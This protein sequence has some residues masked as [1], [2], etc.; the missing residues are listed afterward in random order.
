MTLANIVV[1]ILGIA[2]I[3]AVWAVVYISKRNNE[4]CD[5]RKKI[6]HLCHERNV[7]RIIQLVPNPANSWVLFY[8]N[9]PSYDSML[10]SFKPLKLESY[11]TEEEINELTGDSITFEELTEKF[12]NK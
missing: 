11:Y 2:A 9:L 7:R 12:K 1:A 3:F 4:V 10:H 8:Y 5:F 6:I